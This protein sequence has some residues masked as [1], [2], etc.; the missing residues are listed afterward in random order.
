MNYTSRQEELRDGDDLLSRD[1]LPALSNAANDA[2]A[3]ADI[4]TNY[5]DYDKSHVIVLTDD[6][7][8]DSE[9]LP[10]KSNIARELLRV[11]KEADE[12]DTILLTKRSG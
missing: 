11:S 5:Y 3:I 1:A 9:R 4:L 2:L 6:K 12:D 7:G 10:T 8:T